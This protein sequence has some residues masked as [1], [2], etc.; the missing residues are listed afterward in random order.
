ML[1]PHRHGNFVH[2]KRFVEHSD[3]QSL[4]CKLIS[5]IHRCLVFT[6]IG[7]IPKHYHLLTCGVREITCAFQ[8]HIFVMFLRSARK[9]L[10]SK[11]I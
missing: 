11:M 1:I 5:D 10:M 3:V 6:L 8:I 2:W 4:H 7:Q 9:T